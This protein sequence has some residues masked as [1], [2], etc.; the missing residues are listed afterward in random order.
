LFRLPFGVPTDEV[1]SILISA[2]QKIPEVR[3]R[4]APRVIITETTE[5]WIGLKL[6]FNIDDYGSH[7]KIS[8]RIYT[9]ALAGLKKNGF[10][11]ATHQLLLSQNE[12][13]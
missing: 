5:S 4:P 6:V 10:H 8:D 7:F 11:L 1:K 3:G 2:A 13:K 12:I 9:E